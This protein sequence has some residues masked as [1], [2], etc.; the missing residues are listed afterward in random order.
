VGQVHAGQFVSRGKLVSNRVSNISRRGLPEIATEVRG[1]YDRYPY[2]PPIDSLEEYQLA[3]QDTQKRRADYHLFWPDKPYREDYSILVAG[4]GTSQ[5]ARHAIR[6]PRAHITAIDISAT[7]V[8]CTNELKRRYNLHNLHTHQLPIESVH[9]LGM[10]FDQIVCTGVL[11]HLAEPDAG[12]SALRGV[13]KT[14]GA[15]QLMVYAPYGRTGIY[16]LQECCR[17]LGI[18]ATDEG[19][20]ELTG[21]LRV[22]PPGHPLEHML[23]EVPDFGHE[24]GL[25]DALLH[26]RDRA[27]SVPQLFAFIEKAGLTFGRWVR[28]APYSAHC[29]LMS[30]IRLESRMARLLP[31]EQYA[32]AEL[33]RGTMVRHSLIAY[34][35]ENAPG[36]RRIDFSGDAW[37]CDAWLDYVPI[38]MPDTI[39]VQECLP[40]GAA[41]VLINQT[42]TCKDLFMPID[43]TEKCFFDAIDGSLSIGEI[44]TSVSP[45]L[46]A[47]PPLNKARSFFERLW[48]YD[49]VVFD[50]SRLSSDVDAGD[51]MG[52]AA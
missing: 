4:C 36:P 8:R 30:H 47:T 49:Q 25:A 18:Q 24:A 11:H 2:P 6:W 51:D 33:F 45:P 17:R 44:T 22:L 1:F 43:S 31:E 28:Q 3:W 42:H 26:P 48:Q 7:S 21:V 15:M 52:R 39:C 14:G 27:Y 32:A 20:R 9:A 12:L 19:I 16:M 29:G 41:A 35:N 40:P 13:L 34:R 10:N 46:D 50:A 37:P 23:R 38:R 5:A